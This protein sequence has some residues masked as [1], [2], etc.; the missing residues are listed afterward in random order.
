MSTEPK[1]SLGHLPEGRWDFDAAVVDVFDDMLKR[2]IPQYEVMRQ[3][4]LD[5]GSTFVRP[6]TTVLDLG[7]SRGEAIAPFVT[8]FGAAVHCVGLEVSPPMI[9]AARGRFEA[10][11][12]AGLVEILTH[13]LRQKIDSP[14][15]KG[16]CSL[17]LSV[18]TLQFT[19]IEHRL[20]ILRDAFDALRPGGA[21][22]LVEKVIGGSSAIDEMMTDLY[23]GKK[24]ASGYSQ[25]EVD[26]KRLSLEGVL[27]PVTAAWNE[28]LLRMTGFIEVDCFW[29]WLNFAG[30]VAVRS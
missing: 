29:R 21:L 2:S 7:C 14:H 4:V 17:V 11:R 12:K 22:V 9:E 25:E 18:L 16:T 27:V 3:A 19:P 10:E 13:D 28:D 23:L 8:R 5:V 20:R 30:W 24:K 15:L 26:R 1:S 6:K